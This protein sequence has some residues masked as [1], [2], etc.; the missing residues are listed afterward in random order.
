ML[1]EQ[2]WHHKKC[3]TQNDAYYKINEYKKRTEPSIFVSDIHF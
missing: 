1:T 2:F 3:P